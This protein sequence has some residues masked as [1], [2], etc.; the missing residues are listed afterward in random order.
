MFI[1][2]QKSEAKVGDY[3]LLTPEDKN[4][5]SPRNKFFISDDNDPFKI[6]K[7][8][9][10]YISLYWDENQTK[11][12]FSLTCLGQNRQIIRSTAYDCLPFQI[13]RIR[14]YLR[15]IDQDDIILI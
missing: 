9:Y 8:G 7:I 5:D 10:D 14:K 6:V 11:R 3:V 13:N 1:E 15:K 4:P 2:I 12:W